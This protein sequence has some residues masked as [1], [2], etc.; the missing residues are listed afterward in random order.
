MNIKI[1]EVDIKYHGRSY[2]EG[3]KL[4]EKMDLVQ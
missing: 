4:P 3:K 1:Y 2:M